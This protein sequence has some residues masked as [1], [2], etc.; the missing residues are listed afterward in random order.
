MNFLENHFLN[1]AM[2]K[3]LWVLLLPLCALWGIAQAVS[4]R[5]VSNVGNTL[6]QH[7]LEKS[8]ELP[9]EWQGAPLRPL[10]LSEVELRFAQHFPGSVA[11]MTDGKQVLVQRTVTRPTRM[12][13]P[14]TDC[15]RGLGYRIRNEQLELQADQ[16]RWRCFVADR[17]GRGLRVCER[18]ED[19][20]GQGFTDTSAWYW[21]AAAGQST[22]PWTAITVATPL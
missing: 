12:L 9:T 17:G 16:A 22:G 13:H 2:H 19:A 1:R 10:A 5:S 14:A 11:R 8:A 21:A 18:I 6:E 7:T 4:E 3:M 20:Q 15:Y